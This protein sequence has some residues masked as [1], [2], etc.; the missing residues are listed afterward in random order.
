MKRVGLLG[1]KS[2]T[3]RVEDDVT[4]QATLS[5]PA[6]S[7]L[8]AYRPDGTDE[9]CEPEDEDTPPVRKSQPQ[10]PPPSRSHFRYRLSEGAG[11]NAFA[12]V[13]SHA[14]LPAYREW[15]RRHGPTPWRAGLPC[16]PGVV[17]RDDTRGL[18]PLLADEPS[19]TRGKGA[20]ARDSGE[21][22][23][24]LANWLRG[25]PGVDA[26]AVEAFPVEPASGP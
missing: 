18:Q 8:I 23:A 7:Y 6:F 25:L 24:T 4:V 20:T 14:P 10:Y 5:E 3:T 17:W 21:P 15:K 12:L 22:A 2:F 1:K 16:D 19:R 13:V 9:L 26:V 11:L